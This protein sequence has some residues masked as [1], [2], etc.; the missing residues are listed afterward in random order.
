ML[1]QSKKN[2]SPRNPVSF[3]VIIISPL[4]LFFLSQMNPAMPQLSPPTFL[5]HQLKLSTCR[6]EKQISRE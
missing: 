6:E 1:Q 4:F 5:L 2:K 3:I